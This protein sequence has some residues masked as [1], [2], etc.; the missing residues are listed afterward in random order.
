R[1]GLLIAEAQNITVNHSNFSSGSHAFAS[2][3][4]FPNRNIT[5]ANTII[6]DDSDDYAFDFHGNTSN[7]LI[8]NVKSLGG[9]VYSGAN[10]QIKN[11]TF[12]ASN[13]NHGGFAAIAV[14]LYP[15]VSGDYFEFNN[16]TI[17]SNW[18][19]SLFIVPAFIDIPVE[20][21]PNNPY[22]T[23]KSIAVNNSQII[24]SKIK[25][26]G[27][28]TMYS[29]NFLPVNLNF[30]SLLINNSL[31]MASDTAGINL[32]YK[33]P[34]SLNLNNFKITNN[35]SIISNTVNSV[36]V[37]LGAHIENN[38]QTRVLVQKSNFCKLLDLISCS[39]WVIHL[40]IG[41]RCVVQ[42]RK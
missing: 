22:G 31:V 36:Y 26:G 42:R 10:L 16:S 34:V 11:S 18:L 25:F 9:F 8:D 39:Y 33:N 14:T 19:Y 12:L 6:N 15:E 32:E 2:G 20:N 17:I 29:N 28:L 5:I 1:Y 27:A 4:T 21:Q 24:N 30:T 35:S 38:Y 7:V 13:N 3:G 41:V 37:D 23:I 40:L